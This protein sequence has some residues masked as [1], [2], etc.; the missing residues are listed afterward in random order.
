MNHLFR[1]LV[2]PVVDEY[3]WY[4][5]W[6]ESVDSLSFISVT[7]LRPLGPFPQGEE[8]GGFVLTINEDG[9]VDSTMD[10]SLFNRLQLQSGEYIDYWETNPVLTSLFPGQYPYQRVSEDPFDLYDPWVNIDFSEYFPIR[11]VAEFGRAK[12]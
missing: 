7:L 2:K 6:N 5:G 11:L 8:F 10:I 1:N 4:D 3:F 12:A 9:T